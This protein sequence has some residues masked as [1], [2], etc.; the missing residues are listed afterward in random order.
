MIDKFDLRIPRLTPFA[1][2][3]SSEYAE[4]R[5]DPKGPFRESQHYSAVA[6]LQAYGRDVMLHTF[7]KH[8]NGDHKLEVLD[9]GTKSW[10]ELLQQVR[11][12][13]TINPS[14]LEIIRVDFAADVP[15]VTVPWFHAHGRVKF[16]RFHNAGMGGFE[17][18]Q[19]GQKGIQ[20]LIYGKRPNLN[21]VYDKIAEY[22]HQYQLMKRRSPNGTEF[23][24]FES[25]CG[26]SKDAILTRVERQ[27]GGGK[28][29]QQIKIKESG[30]GVRTVADLWLCAR[31]FD[32]FSNLILSSA[33]LEPQPNDFHNI[34]D[35]LAILQAR[36]LLEAW[37]KH[38]FYQFLNLHTNRNA[39]RWWKKYG[40]WIDVHEGALSN[41]ITSA[42]LYERFHDS[43]TTQLAA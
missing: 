32:P 3:F 38:A 20:T 11:Q 28:L 25:F 35:F 40:T 14:S 41:A 4:L 31:E 43:I 15:G 22:V 6:S 13:F 39:A 17:Y 2:G 26:Y 19:Y 27:I 1:P 9:A 8:G 12:I 42:E 37:G 7:C 21:R 16:K 5:N 33:V 24:T 29:P 10:T 23:P 34:N 30:Q 18:Q 36:E